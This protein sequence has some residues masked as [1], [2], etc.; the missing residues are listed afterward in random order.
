MA[1]NMVIL[2]RIGENSAATYSIINYTL[3]VISMIIVGIS[4]GMQPLLSFHHRAGE[5]DKIQYYYSLSIKS[6]LVAAFA[7]YF[8]FL[9]F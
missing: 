6:V 1:F 3:T 4:Q 9:L 2:K 7:N 5:E 8:I